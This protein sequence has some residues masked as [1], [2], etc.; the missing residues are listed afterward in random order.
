MNNVQNNL[1][2]SLEKRNEAFEITNCSN[3]S[4]CL[5]VYE[6]N[7]IS[8]TIYTLI[9]AFNDYSPINKQ[10]PLLV[11]DISPIINETL[12]PNAI[13]IA[14][15]F[16]ASVFGLQNNGNLYLGYNIINAISLGQTT[17]TNFG[18]AFSINQ[19]YVAATNYKYSYL[20]S[21]LDVQSPRALPLIGKFLNDIPQV[22]SKYGKID[23]NA[24]FTEIIFPIACYVANLYGA[25]VFGL[26]AK[27]QLW[28]G[29]DNNKAI[30]YGSRT[31]SNNLG[32]DWVNRVYTAT[33][34][35]KCN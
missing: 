19:V 5:L 17:C 25:T 18:G 1:P 15:S 12:L 23:L 26:Q 4:D 3:K 8:N 28:L 34:S 11:S 33:K 16:G 14:S 29:Y 27:G 6:G 10:I 32:C 31:C 20:G 2:S 7:P 24:D 9:G 35:N 21:F 22:I 13:N 30:A